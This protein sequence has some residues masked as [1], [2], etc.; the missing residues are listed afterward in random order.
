MSNGVK[1]LVDLLINMV[2]EAKQVPLSAGK[3]VIDRDRVLDL[4][5]DINE[6]LPV[7]LSEAKRILSTKEECLTS[8]QQEADQIRT[9]AETYAKKLLEDNEM[10]NRAKTSA[11]EMVKAAEMRSREL[12]RKAGE[13]CELTL[14]T[15]ETAVSD[16]YEEIKTAKAR[17]RAVIQAQTA[18]EQMA[19]VMPE[20][21]G[22]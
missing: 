13:Y 22:Q 17:F 18:Q 6:M 7:E 5:D 2:D 14:N 21:L 8:A 11:E 15:T 3:C 4:L 10:T 1:E 16:A 9:Q 12:M 20:D 19:R